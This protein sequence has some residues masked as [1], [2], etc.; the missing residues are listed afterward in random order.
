MGIENFKEIPNQEHGGEGLDVSET[1]G[2]V[3]DGLKEEEEKVGKD[4]AENLPDAETGGDELQ[5][6]VLETG[7]KQIDEES[8]VETGD[9]KMEEGGQAKGEI[10]ALTKE[11][12]EEKERLVK[13]AEELKDLCEEKLFIELKDG[14]S[15]N[16]L[17]QENNAEIVK[18]I[19]T[20]ENRLKFMDP[21][22]VKK[23]FG[24]E[25]EAMIAIR[26]YQKK[27]RERKEGLT[28]EE[29]KD[30]DNKYEMI[31]KMGEILGFE[32][33]ESQIFTK[34][35]SNIVDSAEEWAKIEEYNKNV[36][37][38]AE[39]SELKEGEEEKGGKFKNVMDKIKAGGK[40]AGKWGANASGGMA[41]A[42]VAF[43]VAGAVTALAGGSV[44]WAGIG[45]TFGVAGGGL[46]LW[47]FIEEGLRENGMKKGA[48]KIN[49][50][51]D[52]PQVIEKL[53]SNIACLISM[54]QAGKLDFEG[55][56][57]KKRIRETIHKFAM[58]KTMTKEKE[59]E[60][61][62][63]IGHE[64][65][66]QKGK[67]KAG[68]QSI[69]TKL[70]EI[71]SDPFFEENENQKREKIEKT[72]DG[73]IG[74]KAIEIA[75]L[76]REAEATKVLYGM[77]EKNPELKAKF[78]KKGKL[79]QAGEGIKKLGIE[80]AKEMGGFAAYELIPF[81]KLGALGGA[82]KKGMELPDL[83][84]E[85]TGGREWYEQH[86]KL[87]WLAK[88]GC[89]AATFAAFAALM[90]PKTAEGG[91]KGVGKGWLEGIKE[92]AGI[93]GSLGKGK[94]GE[95]G[96][97][98]FEGFKARHGIK[99]SKSA[100]QL[101]AEQE[102]DNR[103]WEEMNKIE[104][105]ATK[106][107]KDIGMMNILL[108]NI[109]GE[110]GKIGDLSM[111]DKKSFLQ[112][113]DLK[114]KNKNH[115]P[116]V[117]NNTRHEVNMKIKKLERDFGDQWMNKEWD[118]F[119][120]KELHKSAV[121]RLLGK[122]NKLDSIQGESVKDMQ[123][124]LND[125]GLRNKLINEV[126][127]EIA[128][129]LKAEKSVQTQAK[130][131]SAP[132]T[133]TEKAQAPKA[134]TEE[135]VEKS[136][137]VKKVEK[138]AVEN[139]NNIKKIDVKQGDTVWKIAQQMEKDLG[140]KRPEAP[141]ELKGKG[142]EL[143]KWQKAQDTYFNDAIKDEI[144]KQMRA[145]NLNPEM[146]KAGQNIDV[147]LAKVKSGLEDRSIVKGAGEL[148]PKDV[149]NILE[150]NT[151]NAEAAKIKKAGKSAAVPRAG[152][153]TAAGPKLSADE[154]KT[155]ELI[156]TMENIG[157]KELNIEQR[158]L[159]AKAMNANGI[160]DGG[161]YEGLKEIYEKTT[162]DEIGR[163]F[164]DPKIQNKETAIK[165]V[166]AKSKIKSKQIEKQIINKESIIQK[167]NDK[168]IKKETTE[169][170]KPTIEQPFDYGEGKYRVPENLKKGESANIL[171]YV[172]IFT[173]D[174]ICKIETASTPYKRGGLVLWEGKADIQNVGEKQKVLKFAKNINQNLAEINELKAQKELPNGL[175]ESQ[176]IE[177]I[178]RN[179]EELK[180]PYAKGRLAKK[181]AEWNTKIQGRWELITEANPEQ[182]DIMQKIV[183]SS[184]KPKSIVNALE[185][186]KKLDNLSLKDKID[187]ANVAIRENAGPLEKNIIGKWLGLKIDNAE[188]TCNG[189]GLVINN[190]PNPN[191]EGGRINV[192]L[193]NG[194]KARVEKA[195][196]SAFGRGIFKTESQ[197]ITDI[198]LGELKQK[199]FELKSRK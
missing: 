184:A 4:E 169:K 198:V 96:G 76:R 48:R 176:A 141:S 199:L 135:K 7:G 25:L 51:E 21:E 139:V 124:Y 74:L 57:E 115:V 99:E 175:S 16:E 56:A 65:K 60:F 188:I 37:K 14:R 87:K 69:E 61:L 85:A 119:T 179:P 165:E 6:T 128:A 59:E 47:K 66:G 2:G 103:F 19:E 118:K 181:I 55:N 83:L 170:F 122:I 32:R 106:D 120:E 186:T 63:N 137:P 195:G 50:K 143:A 30:W 174:G 171:D 71:F 45:L 42:A 33:K 41:K 142:E 35:L 44:G 105:S 108:K 93:L 110:D 196:K 92:D 148:T 138:S 34:P 114:Q 178:A 168:G 153:E 125:E 154:L 167:T 134:K 157:F 155:L 152:G 79:A 36:G 183:Q 150:N 182:I 13:I 151:R 70:S 53:K 107:E 40:A 17:K 145:K 24:E 77:I 18:I 117:E 91:V 133:E 172:D 121:N 97:K 10:S 185:L 1:A 72:K 193:E 131:P 147:D 192:I 31:G 109:K 78:E 146:I 116:S 163:I 136:V 111:E 12:C 86:K 43:K 101:R 88:A 156:K 166:I 149:N 54:E 3:R 129:E 73:A 164:N 82:F 29:E 126:K 5:E 132:K 38:K 173:E 11:E 113:I 75:G 112:D 52:D 27:K 100:E 46:T 159:L 62:T 197:G 22:E 102:I 90:A 177:I 23:H 15:I 187:I 9:S 130:T 144:A 39:K 180:V 81:F 140:I 104:K 64:Q 28:L 194:K 89:G 123:K 190:I 162:R 98:I 68:L 158:K 189:K 161:E 58:D 95:A 84:A 160:R 127:Q 26:Q 80:Y 8:M 94:I 49:L 20:I 191:G 67:F